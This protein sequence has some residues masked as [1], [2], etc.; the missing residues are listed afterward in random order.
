MDNARRPEE[1]LKLI[2]EEYGPRNWRA[3]IQE[4]ISTT[5]SKIQAN[6]ER[7]LAE[8]H[9]YEIL[10]EY[11]KEQARNRMARVIQTRSFPATYEARKAI[12]IKVEPSKR[13]EKPQAE[14]TEQNI[15]IVQQPENNQILLGVTGISHS[16]RESLPGLQ[17]NQSAV[18][19]PQEKLNATTRG[20]VEV[21]EKKEPKIICN[22]DFKLFVIA[23]NSQFLKNARLRKF[24]EKMNKMSPS[25]SQIQA[26]TKDQSA[27]S[28]T[29]SL[30]VLPRGSKGKKYP[31]GQSQNASIILNSMNEQNTAA[32]FS[33]M[34]ELFDGESVRINK[35]HL[36]T[37]DDQR[38]QQ[39]NARPVLLGL[40]KDT[41][42]GK[43]P[44]LL[45]KHENHSPLG[46]LPITPIQMEGTLPD[47]NEGT[48]SPLLKDGG[49]GIELNQDLKTQPIKKRYRDSLDD[50]LGLA[51]L[52]ENKPQY[53]HR[54]QNQQTLSNKLPG[55]EISTGTAMYRGGGKAISDMQ[56][57]VLEANRLTDRSSIRIGRAKSLGNLHKGINQ[58]YSAST[59]R[60]LNPASKMI[61]RKLASQALASILLTSSIP[62]HR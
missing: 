42:G 20:G 16:N 41:S 37:H 61:H 25:S 53:I 9:T 21:K 22:S 35:K 29:K 40:E 54:M 48:K 56:K 14:R 47:N 6:D 4:N 50:I 34:S 62:S 45:Q 5:K 12:G 7:L 13:R 52:I 32:H 11:E 58:Q 30:V 44:L 23:R 57:I 55:M 51:Q 60:L 27:Y 46:T 10:S 59:Q 28:K 3:Q 26:S 17:I 36:L 19:I 1:I 24:H 18:E 33:Q 43:S 39:Y 38:T 49:L 31:E 2:A 8:G 15:D